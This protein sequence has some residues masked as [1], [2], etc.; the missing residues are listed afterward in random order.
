[1]PDNLPA[2][3]PRD[4]CWLLAGDETQAWSSIRGASKRYTFKERLAHARGL[5]AVQAR[6]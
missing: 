1:M 5:S 3:N 4:H 2:C 6:C